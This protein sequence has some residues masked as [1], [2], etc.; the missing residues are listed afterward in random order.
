MLG[1]RSIQ[2]EWGQPV[3]KAAG[4]YQVSYQQDASDGPVASITRDAAA[5]QGGSKL[6]ANLNC[7]AELQQILKIDIDG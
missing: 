4:G 7:S 5:C 3:S 2:Y 6:Q 1:A